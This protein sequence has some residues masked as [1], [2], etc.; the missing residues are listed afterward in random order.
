[1]N[2]FIGISTILAVLFVGTAQASIS[3]SFEKLTNNSPYNVA[4]QLKMEVIDDVTGFVDF[5]FTNEVGIASSITRIYFDDGTLLGIS[6]IFQS[7]GVEFV[8]PTNPGN[9]PGANL[10]S[11]PFVTTAEFLAGSGPPTA[12]NGVDSSEEW[13]TIRFALLD[14][15]TYTDTI[16]ALADGSLRVGLHIQ[17]LPDGESDSYINNGIIPA[18]G[19]VLLGMIGLGLVGW[20]KR[21]LA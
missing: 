9:L 16:A 14:N 10:A 21:R 11:P 18:P 8:T 7:D 19:A 3:Y 4:S 12:S 1:M 2:R 17:S 20:M 6:A 5:K 15:V 13:V